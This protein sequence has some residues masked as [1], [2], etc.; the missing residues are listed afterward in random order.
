MKAL[1]I[2]LC[3]ATG[4]LNSCSLVPSPKR[5]P[6]HGTESGPIDF[7]VVTEDGFLLGFD[8]CGDPTWSWSLERSLLN[9][10]DAQGVDPG[11]NSRMVPAVDGSLYVVFPGDERTGQEAR[12]AHVNATIMSVVAESPFSTPAFP[13][14]YLTGS[15]V[16]SLDSIVFDEEFSGWGPSGVREKYFGRKLMFAINDWTLS[17]IESSSQKQQWGLSFVEFSTLTQA[18]LNEKNPEYVQVSRL[19]SEI[20][21][22]TSSLFN[23]VTKTTGRDESSCRTSEREIFF[24]SRVMGVYAVLDPPDTGGNLVMVLVGNNAPIPAAASSDP[25]HLLPG[26]ISGFRIEYI[27]GV[28]LQRPYKGNSDSNFLS[29]WESTGSSDFSPLAISLVTPYRNWPA[30]R[31]TGHVVL[32]DRFCE[33]RQELPPEAIILGKNRAFQKIIFTFFFA[34]S[35]FFVIK[36]RYFSKKKTLSK[37]ISIVLP[38]GT[39]LRQTTR[40]TTM[41]ISSPSSSTNRLVLIPS[42]AIQ[43]YEV[44][45]VG[46]SDSVEFSPW[47]SESDVEAFDKKIKEI[48]QRTAKLP[49]T[50]SA[51]SRRPSLDSGNATVLFLGRNVD[52]P[53]L[54]FRNPRAEHEV[55]RAN[56][57][58]YTQ[59]IRNAVASSAIRDCASLR[60]YVPRSLCGSWNTFQGVFQEYVAGQSSSSVSMISI[61]KEAPQSAIDTAFLVLLFRDTDAHDGNYVRDLRRKIALFDLGCALADRPLPKE[62][63]LDRVCLDNFEIWRRLPDLLNSGFELRHTEFLNTIDWDALRSMWTKFEYDDH[64]VELS[65]L[66]KSRL[67]HPTTMLRIMR[68]HARFL[69]ECAKNE[70]KFIFAANLMY[71][72]TYDDLWIECGETNIDLFESKLVELARTPSPDH[73]MSTQLEM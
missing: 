11:L 72:G 59:S 64:I 52:E 68:M 38:D 1:W 10:T 65:K 13:N 61:L 63:P 28:A 48:S 14:S 15:K 18:H 24:H 51:M 56:I 25:Q 58:I 23:K 44:I 20:E 41:T 8:S 33:D 53:K 40:T 45:K 30:V 9:A 49:F 42:E 21:I 2:I 4:D 46:Q 66:N 50:H 26:P 60:A 5:S 7:V 70:K 37:Q 43:P 27:A 73:P 71:S 69:E 54:V 6:I 39:E 47:Q 55:Q 34:I 19:A 35:V 31:Q 3:F 67:V 22:S 36:R 12:I 32:L 57:P 17:C 62:D 16:Q 29:A